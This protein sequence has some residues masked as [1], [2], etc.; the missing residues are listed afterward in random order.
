MQH[1]LSLTLVGCLLAVGGHAMAADDAARGLKRVEVPI[2]GGQP[3]VYEQSQ[4]LVI[5]CSAYTAWPKLGGVS[6]DIAAVTTALTNQGFGVTSL[7]NPTLAQLR[8]GLDDFIATHGMSAGNRLVVYF[9]GHGYTATLGDGRQMGYV[10][11]V[12][13]PDPSKDAVAFRSKAMDM[14]SIE[15]LA[16]RI[17]SRH[18]LF[19]FD[20]CFSG[21]LF[22]LRAANE[23]PAVVAEALAKPV[24]QFITSGS[25]KEMVPDQSVFR[26]LFVRGL[27]GE[28]DLSG[29]GWITGTE[30]GAYLFTRTV[31]ESRGQQTPQTGKIRNLDLN[32]GDVVFSSAKLKRPIASWQAPGSQAKQPAA[33]M[34]AAPVVAQAKPG[35][36]LPRPGS[37]D[38][39]FRACLHLRDG[40]EL[41][42]TYDVLKRQ[43]TQELGTAKI[44]ITVHPDDVM[45]F[46]VPQAVATKG[47]D[48]IAAPNPAAGE[49][50][51]IVA[52]NDPSWATFKPR[53][54]FIPAGN[55]QEKF[56]M[57]AK[58]TPIPADGIE[59]IPAQGGVGPQ[60]AFDGDLETMWKRGSAVE[61]FISP[62]FVAPVVC[63]GVVIRTGGY[64]DNMEL[65][66]I[67]FNGADVI[68]ITPDATIS[69]YK[70]PKLANE[71]IIILSFGGRREIKNFRFV[72]NLADSGMGIREFLFLK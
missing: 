72:F 64:Y 12:D 65:A 21:S 30:L 59:S 3:L 50:G 27:E 33:P 52:W 37:A 4:A 62:T 2:S 6:D 9:A 26:R 49:I 61:S 46:T 69:N 55:E 47:E 67:A 40:R 20:S 39:P 14:R 18:A 19:V 58:F 23:T 66:S 41:T 32:Q 31:A 11:P 25:A 24:R 17:E 8:Q 22:A 54:K 38:A 57:A 5:G 53:I 48:G 7:A 44:V 45:Q 29:D 36:V 34:P 71:T 51:A 16:E 10:V 13:A 15:T 70:P 63:R 28:A 43:L 56:M 42:G 35:D 1:P 68:A 60:R